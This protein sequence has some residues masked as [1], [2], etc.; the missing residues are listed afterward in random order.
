MKKT[1]RRLAEA[2]RM[3]AFTLIELLVVI[4]IIGIL[5]GMLLPALSRA[6]E[7]A[8]RK[9]CMNNLKQIGT[10]IRLYSAENGDFMP[11]YRGRDG[12]PTTEDS[13]GKV[14]VIPAEDRTTTSLALLYPTF[15]E[16]AIEIFRCLSTEDT[17]E[18]YGHQYGVRPGK[19]GE[20]SDHDGLTEQEGIHR[21]Q[22]SYGYDDTVSFRLATL[23]TAIMADM[24]GTSILNPQSITANHQGGQNVLYYDTSVRWV[25]SNYASQDQTDHIY[26]RNSDWHVDSDTIIQRHVAPYPR[27]SDD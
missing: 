18:L 20:A 21:S 14:R 15:V 24:D 2:V 16:G 22:M 23:K 1:L 19:F 9:A 8:R 17:P 10:A 25:T 27:M 6:R 11:Y 26:E 4:A 7:E 3:S 13:F 5:A 12:L